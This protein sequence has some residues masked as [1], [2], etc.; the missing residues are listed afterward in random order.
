MLKVSCI[1]HT[2][3]PY[4]ILA[5]GQNLTSTH[6]PPPQVIPQQKSRITDAP[7]PR[8]PPSDPAIRSTSSAYPLRPQM[9]QTSPILAAQ[10]RNYQVWSGDGN[11]GESNFAATV[12]RSRM[13]RLQDLIL[14]LNQE[15]SENGEESSYALELRGRIAE[16]T[17]EDIQG[18]EIVPQRRIVPPSYEATR[19]S[20]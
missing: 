11:E 17:R 7:I 13:Q 16:L 3:E 8:Q 12:F 15:I 19:A 9:G 1:A 6:G 20:Q 4:T 5:T 14:E 18:S 10:Q 2:A